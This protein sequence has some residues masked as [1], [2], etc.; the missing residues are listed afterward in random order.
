[1]SSSNID[2]LPP[3]LAGAAAAAAPTHATLAS[4]QH[5]MQQMQA[6]Q[7]HQTDLLQRLNET[8]LTSRAMINDLVV[9]NNAL[10]EDIRAIKDAGGVGKQTAA[11]SST[12]LAAATRPPGEFAWMRGMKY[13]VYLLFYQASSS[14]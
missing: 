1:M 11:A 13:E 7:V 14:Y 4:L 5:S 3:P 6:A 12:M 8:V 2:D 10:R 9:Q